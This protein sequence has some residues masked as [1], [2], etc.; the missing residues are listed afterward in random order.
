MADEW[1]RAERQKEF[2]KRLG[3]ARAAASLGESREL[4]DRTLNDVED[5]FSG[6]PF[7]PDSFLSDGRMYP[8]KMTVPS[9]SRTMRA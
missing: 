7:N 9:R 2:F 6:V 5:E 4:I 3:L 8:P 1:T